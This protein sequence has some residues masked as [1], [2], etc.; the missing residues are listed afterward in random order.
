MNIALLNDEMLPAG[1]GGAPVVVDRLRRG[2]VARG[3]IVTLIT[4]HQEESRGSIIRSQ[5]DAGSII[6]I[7]SNVP[8]RDRHRRCVRNPFVMKV[9]KEIWTEDKPDV[10]HAHNLHT[11]LSYGALTIARKFTDKVFLTAHD[12]FLVTFAR[13]NSEAYRR[14]TRA[15]HP[16]RMRVIDH[17]KAVGRRYWPFRNAGIKKTLRSTGTRVIAVSRALEDFLRANRIQHTVVIPNCVPDRSLPD[18][19][20][21]EAFREK[22]R[23]DGPTILFAGRISRDKG[24][25]ALLAAAPDILAQVPNARFLIAGEEK[26]LQPSLAG[27]SAQVRA[28]VRTTGWLDQ[29]EM[30][31]AYGAADVVTTPSICLDSF[32]LTNIEAMQA[33]KPVVGTIFGGTAEIVKD[34]VTGILVDPTDTRSYASALA[35]LLRDPARAKKMGEAGRARVHDQFSLEKQISAHETLYR[36]K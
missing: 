30:P 13:V 12:T 26:R 16:Y 36:S 18:G 24:I 35:E 27:I 3:H 29:E 34:S 20:A 28:A 31:L 22:Y 23:L 32:N 7:Y 17:V 21:V 9:L 1:L 15:G 4:T 19:T 6:S 10:V 11:N 14:A 2:F 5:D 33:G 8:H 25:D